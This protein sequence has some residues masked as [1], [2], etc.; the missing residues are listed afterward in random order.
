M[1]SHLYHSTIMGKLTS[2]NGKVRGKIGATVFSVNAG[3]IIAREYNPSVANPNSAAQVNQRAK[4]KLMG[5]LAAALA[6]VIVIPKDGLT[7]SRNLFVKKN[8]E[9]CSANAGVAQITYENVQLTNGNAGLPGIVAS[10]SAG[11]GV[12]V[13]LEARADAA[14][15]RVCYIMYKKTTEANLQYVQSTIVEAAG[16]NGTFP[17][18]LLYTEGDIILF[19]YGMK[20][21][22]ESASAKFGNMVVEN[23]EDIAKLS[24]TRNF[25]A[26]DFQFTQTRGTTLFAAES[27]T[28]QVGANEARVYLTP[29]GPG[30]VSGAGVFTIGSEVTVTATPNAGSTFVGWRIN[31]SDTIVSHSTTY[32][33]TLNGMTD[34][35]AVF[36]AAASAQVYTIDVELGNTHPTNAAV[37]MNPAN[38]IVDA[39]N[40]ITVTAT[41][42]SASG[43]TWQGWYSPIQ[44]RMVSYEMSY[45]FTPNA[46][47]TLEA[48]WTSKED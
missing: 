42:S 10:R 20:D 22:S 43:F 26:S 48:R 35:I 7:S 17:G 47:D 38:G 8:F 3:Q 28:T 21:L 1:L 16:A 40:P 33:F 45:T 2:L 39:G 9:A 12:S 29:S 14:V 19:A 15:S 32:T 30:S 5:Q 44:G 27:E 46:D 13:Q 25:S 11:S 37:S 23:A 18:S 41:P 31:G 36:S 6:P 24:I 34:L 4:F